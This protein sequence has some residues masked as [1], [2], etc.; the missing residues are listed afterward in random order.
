MAR[1]HFGTILW[2]SKHINPMG[3]LHPVPQNKSH[4]LHIA[5]Q[6]IGR[7]IFIW[8]YSR[9]TRAVVVL[10][11]LD[12]YRDVLCCSSLNGSFSC[13]YLYIDFVY[14]VWMCNTYGSNQKSWDSEHSLTEATDSAHHLAVTWIRNI[15]SGELGWVIFNLPLNLSS[16]NAFF[17]WNVLA[18]TLSLTI[19]NDTLWKLYAALLSSNIII[20]H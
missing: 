14:P 8:E 17:F 7:L 4:S 6:E 19:K 5:S 3:E 2:F 16:Y 15:L 9:S 12:N 11:P 13:R 18:F 1:E 20:L 10:W